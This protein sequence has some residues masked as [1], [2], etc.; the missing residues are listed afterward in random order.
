MG[1][2]VS[3]GIK[4]DATDAVFSEVV[5]WRD[6]WTCKRCHEQILPPTSRIQCAHIFSRGKK[7][8]RWDLENAFTLC[9]GCHIK[10]DQEPDE[11]YD[12]Y[13]SL[14]GQEQFEKLRTRS[15]IPKRILPHEKTLIRLG[16]KEELK[17]YLNNILGHK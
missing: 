14:Y 4:R 1:E 3:W 7:S 16:L 5:R 15:K 12:L 17:K 13:I 10:L 8:T 6:E 9:V 2:N 11:K